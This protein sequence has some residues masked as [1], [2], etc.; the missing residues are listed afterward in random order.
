MIRHHAMA[1]SAERGQVAGLLVAEIGVSP[2]MDF[3]R[4]VFTVAIAQAAAKACGLEFSQP[5][6]VRPPRVAPDV[7]P[8]VHSS[9]PLLVF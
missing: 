6:G 1:T 3:E 2:V 8:V 4:A 9:M 5:R 7:K